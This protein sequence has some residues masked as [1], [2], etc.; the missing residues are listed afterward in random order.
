M[1]VGEPALAATWLFHQVIANDSAVCAELKI[2]GT[3]YELFGI[4]A[5]SGDELGGVRDLQLDLAD[6][7]AV[8]LH[9][10]ADAMKVEVVEVVGDAGILVLEGTC[11]ALDADDLQFHVF[12]PRFLL[13]RTGGRILFFAFS[14]AAIL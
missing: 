8:D 12:F 14:L 1:V 6:A 13:L 4:A 10:L 5:H 2:D 7:L 9:V 11:F 3:A